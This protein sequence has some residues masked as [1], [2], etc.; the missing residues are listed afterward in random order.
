VAT[1]QVQ[2]ASCLCGGTFGTRD[3]GA[4][5]QV[6]T[7]GGRGCDAKEEMACNVERVVPA[8]IHAMRH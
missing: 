7:H 2:K 4:V 3:K 6:Y 8:A 1:E 5:H